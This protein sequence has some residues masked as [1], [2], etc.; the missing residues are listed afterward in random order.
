MT[1]DDAAVVRQ[2]SVP[3]ETRAPTGGTNAYVIDDRAERLL[4]D[5]AGRTAALDD[6][7]AERRPAHIAVTHTHPD[8]I[9]ALVSYAFETSAELWALRGEEN[10]FAQAT[11]V[12]PGRVYGDGEPVGPATV[13]ETPGHASDHAAFEVDLDGGETAI[14]C[15]DLAVAAGSVFV[16]GPDGDMTAYLASLRRLRDRDPDVLYPGHGPAIT[17]PE[18]TLTRLVEH[19]LRREEKVLA[20]VEAGA[21]NPGAVLEAAY[22]KDLSGVRDLARR[23]VISHLEKLAREHRVEWDANIEYVEPA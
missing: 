6:A 22:D 23:T 19:R 5:P 16:G 10:R 13:L 17:D 18:A 11:G 1:P 3:V 21:T 4:V 12:Y 9:G 8:H 14:V 20:A 7:V 2:F 15:G